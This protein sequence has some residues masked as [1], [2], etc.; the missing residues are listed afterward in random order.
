MSGDV[1]PFYCFDFTDGQTHRDFH[2]SKV[3][4]RLGAK[5]CGIRA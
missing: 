1:M 5:P 3:M 2:D 4:L